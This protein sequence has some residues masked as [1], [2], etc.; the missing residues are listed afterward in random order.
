VFLVCIIIFIIL[1]TLVIFKMPASADN[2]VEVSQ[3]WNPNAVDIPLYDTDGKPHMEDIVQMLT[4]D[5]WLE[6]ALAAIVNLEP[7]V[8][9]NM[10]HDNGDGTVTV[11]L[12]D[13]NELDASQ[14]VAKKS[15]LDSEDD[16]DSPAVWVQVIQDAMTSLLEH[17][18]GTNPVRDGGDPRMALGAIY[19]Q[20]AISPGC[21]G[22]GN[23]ALES[24]S[25]PVT[26]CTNATKKGQ[27]VEDHCYTVLAGPASGETPSISLRNPWGVVNENLWGT[28]E[29]GGRNITNLGD[30]K[31]RVPISIALDQCWY[32]SHLESQPN[33]RLFRRQQ[34]ST[35]N[36][37]YLNYAIII[38]TFGLLFSSIASCLVLFIIRKKRKTSEVK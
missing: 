5:C 38:T 11:K 12:Y 10:L 25:T 30:G 28:Q 32:I 16:E 24:T 8:I 21:E 6:A 13:L 18:Y 14:K 26:M 36:P 33:T 20:P 27:L 34:E 35:P 4:P 29:N 7:D 37:K 2:A 1:L 23:A 31:L 3:Q 22:L 9:T 17:E 15:F 19:G